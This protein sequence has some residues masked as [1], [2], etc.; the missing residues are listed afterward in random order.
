[1]SN[2]IWF[3]ASGGQQKGPFPEAQFRDLIARRIVQSDTLV[4]AEGMVGWQKAGEVPGLIPGAAPPSLPADASAGGTGGGPLSVD[5]PLWSF[6]GWCILVTIGNLLVIPSP[7]TGTAY[8]RWLFPRIHVPQRPNLA[9]TGQVGDIWYIFIAMGLAGALGYL[10]NTPPAFERAHTSRPVLGARS[11]GGRQYQF[12]WSADGDDFHR[13]CLGHARLA[14]PDVPRRVHGHRL[15][16]GDRCLGPVALPSCQRNAPRDDLHRDWSSSALA[17]GR[18][19]SRMSSHHSD[20]LGPALVLYLE[21]EP[22]RAR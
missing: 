2:R 3:H 13:Q 18:V 15:G 7:W 14:D 9:F 22:I 17:Y 1:M 10:D 16:L 8:Y 11:L 5:L 21:H 6:L 12:E 20:P 19:R 4:W